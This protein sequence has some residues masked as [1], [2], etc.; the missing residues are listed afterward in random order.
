MSSTEPPKSLVSNPRYLT[1]SRFKQALECPTKLFYSGKSSYI[2]N[3]LDNTF[4]AALAEGGFQVG[5][6][7]C[8]MYPDGVEVTDIGHAAQLDRT[9]G[10][11]QLENIT[12]YEAALESQGLFVRVDILRKSGNLIE[13]VEVKAKSFDPTKDGSFRNSKGKLRP[14]MLPYLQDIA[15]QCHVAKLAYPQFQY[16]CFLMLANKSTTTT[17]SGLNQGFRL[18][19]NGRQRTVEL[20]PS[21]NGATIGA[22]IL[23]AISVDDQVAEI[24]A[25]PLDVSGRL[26][27]IA[28]AALFFAQAYQEDRRIPATPGKQCGGCEFKSPTAP[29]TGQIGSG[30]HECWSDAFGWTNKDFSG[31][32]V[33]DIGGLRNKDDLIERGVLKPTDVTLDDLKFDGEHPG[34]AGMTGK[35]RQW[36]QCSGEWPGGGEYFVDVFGLAAQMKKWRYPLHFID[37]E[38][39]TVAIP[40]GQD[41]RPYQ[42]VAFQF[43]H[44]VM[45]EDGRVSHQT[46]F[47]EATPG[48]D[49]SIPF[50][51][52]LRDALSGNDGTVFRWSA[53]ENTVLNHLRSQLLADPDAPGDSPELIAFVESITSRQGADQEISGP[54]NMVDLCQIASR[55][56][57]HPSTKGSSSLKKVLPALMQSSEALK[58]LYSKPIYGTPTFP[59]LN[60]VTPTTWWVAQDGHVQDPYQLLPQIFSDLDQTDADS[61]NLDTTS[62][63]HDGGAAMTAYAR[64]QFEDIDLREREAINSALLRYCELDTL[65]MVMAVQA[66]QAWLD[67]A[68]PTT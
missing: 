26:L 28:E 56:Y 44:H 33:L 41:Q 60:L 2:N 61:L 3:S 52:A 13:L 27:P 31:G 38:T 58:E 67:D 59:S 14:D 29:V 45:K 37:F 6:L 53:H 50:L 16:R 48:V 46:Q 64:L 36:Y 55:Y 57:F 39:C 8:L 21:I 17:V 62:E 30:F 32:T 25:T 24:L 65:A 18:K 5:A 23:T 10:L 40:F 1:K 47:L 22:P 42:T 12:I 63:L 43:S 9:R 66:W 51:R 49:P 68:A 20:A 34:H 4:L 54:R 11:L 35:H 15:F 19:R 7:A